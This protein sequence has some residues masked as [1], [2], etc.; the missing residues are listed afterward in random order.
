[1]TEREKWAEARGYVRAIVRA[2][3]II[4]RAE[5]LF[6]RKRR[7]LVSG[8]TIREKPQTPL[9]ERTSRRAARFRACHAFGWAFER[10]RR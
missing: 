4:P 1:M 5:E 8:K 7:P 10:E 3:E 2:A 6:V 9:R